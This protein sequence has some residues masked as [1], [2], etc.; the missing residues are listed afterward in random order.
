MFN[1]VEGLRCTIIPTRI[2]KDD[3]NHSTRH[4]ISVI[5]RI[6]NRSVTNPENTNDRHTLGPA[7]SILE[8]AFGVLDT[9]TPTKDDPS[10]DDDEAEDDHFEEAE[11][12][13]DPHCCAVVGDDDCSKIRRAFRFGKMHFAH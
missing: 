2:R 4:R 9:R 8:M 10:C 1:P 6:E 7:E 11:N 5:T 3:I 13:G 12:V